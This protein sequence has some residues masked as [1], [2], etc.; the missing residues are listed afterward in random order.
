MK[1]CHTFNFETISAV[2][3]PIIPKITS[4]ESSNSQQKPPNCHVN[5]FS[6]TLFNNSTLFHHKTAKK[7][8]YFLATKPGFH[9]SQMGKIGNRRSKRLDSPTTEG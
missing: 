4:V 2:L 9:L 1:G 5:Q 3:R 6:S 7:F 8:N